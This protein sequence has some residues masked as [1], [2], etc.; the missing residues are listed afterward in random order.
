MGDSDFKPPCQKCGSKCCKYIAIEIDKPGTKTEYDYIRWYLFHR[1]MNVFVDHDKK[2]HVEFKT[3]CEQL[4]RDGKCMVYDT[5]PKICRT[6][7]ND[8]EECEYYDSP[9]HLYFSDVTEYEKYLNK[10]KIDWK[11]KK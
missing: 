11:F 2:W 7:G 3:P 10:K 6:H 8:D 9:Y 1:D 4:D 5:R